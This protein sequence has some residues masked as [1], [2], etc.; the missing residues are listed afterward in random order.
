MEYTVIL[1]SADVRSYWRGIGKDQTHAER[2]EEGEAF[3]GS[4]GQSECR[5]PTIYTYNQGA[6]S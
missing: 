3:V 4:M 5:C 2:R 1:T 6:I